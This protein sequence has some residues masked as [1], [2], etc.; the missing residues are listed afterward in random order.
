MA[1]LRNIRFNERGGPLRFGRLELLCRRR[2]AP[3]DHVGSLFGDHEHRSGRVGRW[4]K[5][6]DRGID[7]AQPI[8]PADA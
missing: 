7:N 3:K 5:R 1:C 2:V 4:N 6:H 8:K